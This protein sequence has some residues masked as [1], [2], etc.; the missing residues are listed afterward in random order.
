MLN[1]LGRIPETKTKILNHLR[2]LNSYLDDFDIKILQGTVQVFLMEGGQVIPSSR[3]SD[4]TLRFLC[5][6]AILCHPTPPP[7]VCIEEPELGLHP[8]VMPT[9]AALLQEASTRTQLVVTTHS[10][11]LVE[12][13]I[14]TP[15]SVITFS[16]IDG[17]T[18][19]QRL[20]SDALEDWL[21]N[22]TLGI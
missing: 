18:R 8:E 21:D 6:L 7:L 13:F 19:A 11:L 2:K 1:Q 14:E 5:L 4:G 15:E 20:D 3:L 16:K 17:R 10:D 9:L 12:E 22:Y